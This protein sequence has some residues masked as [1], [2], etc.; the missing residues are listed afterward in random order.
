VR[1]H[2]CPS[3]GP[4]YRKLKA[5]QKS[6]D[7]YQI[8]VMAKPWAFVH[9][10]GEMV[11]EIRFKDRSEID[12]YVTEII[13]PIRP[14]F[15]EPDHITSYWTAVVGE[16]AFLFRQ[17]LPAA[18]DPPPLP[19]LKTPNPWSRTMVTAPKREPRAFE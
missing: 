18:V 5:T 12:T 1:I 8:R 6:T 10:H 15:T 14:K 16:H 13:G 11:A 19:P 17:E 2:R 3:C 4:S 9:V 7:V